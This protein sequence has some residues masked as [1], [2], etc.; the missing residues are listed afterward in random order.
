MLAL[1]CLEHMNHFLKYN[2]C[3]APIESTMSWRGAINS[4]DGVNKVSKVL[5][6]SCMY[7]AS[8]FHFAEVQQCGDNSDLINALNDFLNKHLLHWIEC[9]SVIGVLPTG[10]TSLRGAAAALLVSGSLL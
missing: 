4:P 10:L 2:I 7:W 6:Y 5:K 9:L 1:K 8:H 3:E